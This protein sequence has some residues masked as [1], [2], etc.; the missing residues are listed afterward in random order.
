M[1]ALT[2]PEQPRTREFT[3][4]IPDHELLLVF[5][6][7]V[8][9]ERF[10]DWLDTLGWPAFVAWHDEIDAELRDRESGLQLAIQRQAPEGVE[11]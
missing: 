4:T 3:Q 6:D 5:R 7:D 8:T 9:A 2:P 1:S 11:A 10:S